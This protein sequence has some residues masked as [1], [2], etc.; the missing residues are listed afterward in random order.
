MQSSRRRPSPSASSSASTPARP[1]PKTQRKVRDESPRRPRRPDTKTAEAGLSAGM[2][3][4]THRDVTGACD[5]CSSSARP[6]D[7]DLPSLN[8]DH[9]AR[10]VQELHHEPSQELPPVSC[11]CPDLLDDL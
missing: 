10:F 8:S 6:T 1:E 4:A 11:S 2:M 3:G 5:R 9:L 7:V